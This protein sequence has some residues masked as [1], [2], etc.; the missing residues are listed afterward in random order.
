MVV[1]DECPM[2]EML[3]NLQPKNI[4]KFKYLGYMFDEKRTDDVDRS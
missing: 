3:D 1:G 4:S 2:C